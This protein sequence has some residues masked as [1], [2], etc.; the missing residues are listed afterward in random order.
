M[1]SVGWWVGVGVGDAPRDGKPETNLTSQHTKPQTNPKRT[2][3]QQTF[4]HTQPQPNPKH[5]P[6]NTHPK[7][8][9]GD[10]DDLKEVIDLISARF[11]GHPLFAV[12]YSAGSSLLGR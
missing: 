11:P 8:T 4:T 2:P 9:T 1:V 7:K 3:K 12:G 6:Q 10:Q 5:T